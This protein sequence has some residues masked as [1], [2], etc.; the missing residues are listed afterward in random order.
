MPRISR[1]HMTCCKIYGSN[2]K[3]SIFYFLRISPVRR[4][5]IKFMAQNPKKYVIF[6]VPRISREHTNHAVKITA[7]NKNKFV[8]FFMP[9]ISRV[10]II[11]SKINSIKFKKI[12][13]FF[14]F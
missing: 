8:I 6:S 12:S 9:M 11:C 13:D 2:P 1:V 10:H 14:C 4:R 7:Q 5:A 3:N